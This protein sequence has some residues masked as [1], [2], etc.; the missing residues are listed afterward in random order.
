MSSFSLAPG[1][2]FKQRICGIAKRFSDS[3]VKGLGKHFTAIGKGIYGN[4]AN[5]DQLFFRDVAHRYVRFV[6]MRR[7]GRQRPNG[8]I[9]DYIYRE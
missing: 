5:Q 4:S 9:A 3:T 6:R 7:R 8:S 1:L 2:Y